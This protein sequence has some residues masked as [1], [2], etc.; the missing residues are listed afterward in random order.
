MELIFLLNEY[1]TSLSP[2]FTIYKSEHDN[3][4]WGSY[5]YKNLFCACVEYTR[6]YYCKSEKLMVQ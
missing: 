6:Y 5:F 3:K 4:K 1:F 2:L